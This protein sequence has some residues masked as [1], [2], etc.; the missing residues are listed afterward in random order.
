MYINFTGLYSYIRSSTADFFVSM[1]SFW[2]C[3][4]K[5]YE[6]ATIRTRFQGQTLL[7]EPFQISINFV[8]FVKSEFQK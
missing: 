7:S 2:Y 1:A 3:K 6:A 5:L 8:N 4:E